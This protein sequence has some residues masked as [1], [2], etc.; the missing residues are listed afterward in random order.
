MN[1]HFRNFI[2]LLALFASATCFCSEESNV[3]HAM[4]A[5][6]VN[7]LVD[8]D[9]FSERRVST[10]G[11]LVFIESESRLY[12]SPDDARIGNPLHSIKVDIKGTSIALERFKSVNLDWVLLRGTFEEGKL[13][14]ID[15]LVSW[16]KWGRTGKWPPIP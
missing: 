15:A 12:L 7:L 9:R 11:F 16:K 5:P 4:R 2:T 3:E 14:K 1:Y 10:V 6:L 13:S 8:P